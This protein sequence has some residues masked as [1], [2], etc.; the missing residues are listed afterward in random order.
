MT[1]A[2]ENLT[3]RR[4]CFPMQHPARQTGS[5]SMDAEGIPILAS[6]CIA[7]APLARN[8]PAVS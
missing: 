3:Y 4:A 5:D 2:L 8:L 1:S 6:A 7:N